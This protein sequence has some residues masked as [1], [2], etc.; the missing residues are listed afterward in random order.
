ADVIVAG[1]RLQ[2]IGDTAEAIRAIGRKSLAISTDVTDSSSVRDLV[3]KTMEL[4]GKVDVL[5][6][7]AGL[8]RGQGAVPIWD[9]SDEMWREGIDANLT[10]A[11]YCARAVSKYMVERG[12]GKIINISSGYGLRGARDNYMY[13]CAKG[14]IIQLTRSLAVSLSRYGV[15]SNAIVPGLF[16]TE[17]TTAS[18]MELPSGEFI[19]EG[20]TGRPAELGPVVVW[21]ASAAS[22]YMTGEVFVIDGGGL[23]GGVAPTG[24]APVVRWPS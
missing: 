10:G 11:F 20:R 15:T 7:N 16:P 14:G 21:L 4:L 9:V 5:V 3:G 17:A 23:A 2:P 24:D 22:D 6:N 8:V 18:S 12:R 13:A 1:R 19:P